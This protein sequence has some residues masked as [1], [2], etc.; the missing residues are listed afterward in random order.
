MPVA[1][2]LALLLMQQGEPQ[3]LAANAVAHPIEGTDQTIPLGPVASLE[4]VKRLGHQR[5]RLFQCQ[6]RTPF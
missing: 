2:V 3:T 5:R 6:C 1:F 4:T